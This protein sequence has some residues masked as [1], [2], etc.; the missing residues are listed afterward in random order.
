[1]K[2][3]FKTFLLLLAMTALL[4]LLGEWLGG[5]RG[6]MYGLIMAVVMNFFSYWFSDKIV[7]AMYRAR[8]PQ[9]AE[10]RV[11][12]LVQNLATQANLPMP[13]V[14]IIDTPM[15]NAFATGRNPNHAV[16]AAT[17]GILNILDDRELT[18]V[19]AHELGHVRNRDILIGA[20]AATMAGAITFLTR[21]ALFFGGDRD[22]NALVTLAVLILAPLAAMLIQLAISRSREYAADR[23]AGELTNRPMDLV[24]ALEK[25]HHAV[26][27]RPAEATVTGNNTAH[28]FIVNPFKLS[29]IAALFSTHPTLEQRAERLRALENELRDQPK[30]V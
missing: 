25:L 17:T 20:I 9:P 28:L 23:S 26:K 22:R 16:V 12:S 29:G 14:K 8:D 13:K 3:I 24:S 4:M 11:V 27:L 30:E 6:M 7:L 21:M 10:R 18:A 2:N 5:P 19:L 1:M 15:P